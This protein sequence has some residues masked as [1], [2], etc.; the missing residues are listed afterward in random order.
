MTYFWSLNPRAFKAIF[1]KRKRVEIRI[2]TDAE[3]FDYGSVADGDRVI[4]CCG[5]SFL[6]CTVGFVRGYPSVRE[7]LLSEGT[8][9][10]LSSTDDLE[11]GV[12][13]VL[14]FPGYSQGER[15][16]GAYAVGLSGSP[17]L[18]KGLTADEFA[19]LADDLRREQTGSKSP[20]C[21]SLHP[22]G[23]SYA[24]YLVL[25]SGKRPTLPFSVSIP[26]NGSER[27]ILNLSYISTENIPDVAISAVFDLSLHLCA[28]KNIFELVVLCRKDGAAADLLSSC[29]GEIV[30]HGAFCPIGSSAVVFGREVLCKAKSLVVGK[31]DL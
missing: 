19:S 16:N 4:F 28:A 8:E 12:R 18:F 14:G 31:V 29:G 6:S 13:S 20:A 5:R 7:L 21:A 3:G 11:Q 27:A 25:V 2:T 24:R 15:E 22:W 10:T 9:Y 26:S 1:E 17:E 23:M 30:K